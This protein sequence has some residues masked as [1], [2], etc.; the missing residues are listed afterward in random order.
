ME[1]AT[2]ALVEKQEAGDKTSEQTR[3]SVSNP[4]A[5]E[6]GEKGEVL[7]HLVDGG[8]R[9][10]KVQVGIMTKA[11]GVQGAGYVVL[12]EG[13]SMSKAGTAQATRA[14]AAY[15]AV[16]NLLSR[17]AN[18]DIDPT[19]R[20]ASTLKAAVEAQTV[21]GDTAERRGA[22]LG[23]LMTNNAEALATFTKAD[24]LL[25]DEALVKAM[26]ADKRA[27]LQAIVKREK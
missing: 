9:V 23:A 16:R 3:R 26:P 22:L 12:R 17:A 21:R 24:V 4:F 13:T 19:Q 20:E 6:I 25:L 14:D 2:A 7:L 10:G 18:R 15:Y 8:K 27:L 5:W 1:T 11:Q